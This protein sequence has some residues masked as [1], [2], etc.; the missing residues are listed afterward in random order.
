MP[1]RERKQGFVET[2]IAGRKTNALSGLRWSGASVAANFGFQLFFTALMARMLDPSAFGLMAMC[3]IAIR[4]FSYFSQAGLGAA[5]VQ[6]PNLTDADIRCALGLTWC[7]GLGAVVLFA[8]CA[9][10]LGWFFR[11]EE[12]V[13]LQQSLALNLLVLGLGAIPTALL[14]RQMRFRTLAMVETVSYVLGYGV[15]GVAAAAN[16]WGLWS[17][18][19]ATYGQS[20]LALLLGIASA[21]HSLIPSLAGDR[22]GLL[23]YGGRHS[24]IGFLEFLSANLDAAMIGRLLGETSL[25]LYNRA[26]LLTNQP[27]ERAAGILTRVLFPLLASVQHDRA[28]VGVVMLLGIWLVGLFGAAF[29]LGLSAAAG[30]V[31]ELLLGSQWREA[32][33]VVQIL[34]FS[35]PFMFMSNIAGVTCDA[36]ALLQFKFR[37]QSGGL[38][39][40]ASLLALLA[41]W[42][43]LGLALAIVI[44]EAL[45]LAIYITFLTRALH[46]NRTEV[47]R[48]VASVVLGGVLCGSTV[49]AISEFGAIAKLML[50]VRVAIETVGGVLALFVACVVSLRIMSGSQVSMLADRN[51]PGW[52]RWRVKLAA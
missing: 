3:V 29:S 38:A 52:K 27:V 14:R 30:D 13:R 34:A 23:G 4:L 50:P 10:V 49:M 26:L 46:C 48:V 16:G 42:G 35:V 45:R 2:E 25:G 28:R 1:E 51:L 43:L 24:V 8:V 22:R 19:A 20:F 7:I 11:N 31:V 6:R 18:V 12:V 17:L 41:P 21:R 37:V 36:L 33:P 47:I 5:L 39:M 32:V 44:G 9:P 40:I 15:V